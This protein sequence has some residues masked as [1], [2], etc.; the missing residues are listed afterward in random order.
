MQHSPNR[1][2]SVMN[3]DHKDPD[4]P[5]LGNETRGAFLLRRLSSQTESKRIHPSSNGSISNNPS[6]AQMKNI[7]EEEGV[8]DGEE[9]KKVKGKKLKNLV[10]IEVEETDSRQGEEDC[11]FLHGRIGLIMISSFAFYCIMWNGVFS[12]LPLKDPMAFAVHS[13][14]W[15]QPNALLCILAG[16]GIA[17]M[18]RKF[19]LFTRKSGSAKYLTGCRFMCGVFGIC[20]AWWSCRSRWPLADQRRDG[21]GFTMHKYGEAILNV[22]P[23]NALLLSHTDLDWNSVRYLR[24]CEGRRPDVTHLSVQLLPYPWFSRQKSANSPALYPGV[25]FPPLFAGVS[26][27]KRDEGNARLIEEFLAANWKAF[28]SYGSGA[29]ERGLFIDMQCIDDVQINP[30]GAWRGLFDF[31]PHGPLYRVQLRAPNADASILHRPLALS[32]L[33][34][35]L[36]AWGDEKNR[37]I[38]GESGPPSPSRFVKGSWEFAAGCVHN[39]AI[40]QLSLFFLTSAID[41]MNNIT[42]PKLPVLLGTL[43]DAVRLMDTILSRTNLIDS[44]E[45]GP[46]A[47]YNLTSAQEK[48][49]QTPL[50]SSGWD[51]IKNAAL[52]HMRLHSV[53]MVAVKNKDIASQF[54]ADQQKLVLSERKEHAVTKAAILVIRQFVK[55]QP[56]DK[57]AP[58]FESALV[59]YEKLLRS[60]HIDA[61]EISATS[62][63]KEGTQSDLL[64]KG[65]KRKKKKKKKVPAPT[66][67]SNKAEL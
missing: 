1:R 51:L 67:L 14:F 61:G 10:S 59:Q 53:V 64:P 32:A 57:D 62:A 3:Y 35:M 26:T 9:W 40:Y 30:R 36:A 15:M 16:D 41:L 12:N 52:A 18:L 33:E 34:R 17:E 58:V 7:P 20:I 55:D 2:N 4:D 44:L 50:S 66:R 38:G 11:H 19:C 8:D 45:D 49:A 5:K 6:G 24:Q 60:E 21:H 13:R 23:P 37:A 56:R 43:H 22:L 25:T 65:K 48:Y 27:H 47:N 31:V 28:G 29:V 39:D 63:A 42:V 46:R 54:D